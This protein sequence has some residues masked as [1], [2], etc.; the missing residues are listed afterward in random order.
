MESDLKMK[1]INLIN[2]TFKVKPI[3]LNPFNPNSA[4]YQIILF[5]KNNKEYSLKGNYKIKEYISN[6]HLFVFEKILKSVI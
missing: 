6:K 3:S 4:I 2:G 5:D 1:E